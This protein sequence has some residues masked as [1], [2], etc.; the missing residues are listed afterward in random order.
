M[1]AAVGMIGEQ[2]PISPCLEVFLV[3]EQSGDAFA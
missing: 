1:Q 2:E 3:F